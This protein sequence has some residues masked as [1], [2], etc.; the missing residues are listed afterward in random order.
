MKLL[1]SAFFAQKNEYKLNANVYVPTPGITKNKSLGYIKPNIKKSY[2]C[3]NA[4]NK[5]DCPQ[6]QNCPGRQGVK[7]RGV[8]L[9]M[10]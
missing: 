1:F 8:A 10:P 4:K 6:D 5:N 9:L 3:W 2:E 7:G